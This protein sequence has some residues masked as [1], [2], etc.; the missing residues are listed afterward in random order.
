[1]AYIT[2]RRPNGRRIHEL[3]SQ[4]YVGRGT[5]CQ[6]LL[7]D[8]RSS[9]RHAEIKEKA[10]R[11]L[12]SDL[13]SSNGTRVRGQKVTNE[14]SLEDGD[15]IIIGDTTLVF[16]RG[17]PPGVDPSAAAG[18][19][20]GDKPRKKTTGAIARKTGLQISERAAKRIPKNTVVIPLERFGFYSDSERT[21]ETRVMRTSD[22][23]VDTEHW[24]RTLYRLLREANQCDSEDELFSAATRIL[25]ESLAGS[26]VQVLFEAGPDASDKD[27]LKSR[28]ETMQLVAWANPNR[29]GSR[30]TRIL[31]DRLAE[32]RS[33]LLT[34]ARER[35]VAVL[36]G[37]VEA[38]LRVWEG[39][40]GPKKK[41]TQFLKAMAEDTER[42]RISLLIAPLQ[43]G[44]ISLGYLVAERS[45]R[46]ASATRPRR[47]EPFNQAH[48]EFVAA[49]AYPLASML[50]RVRRRQQVLQENERLRLAV[51]SRHKIVGKSAALKAVLTVIQRVAPLTSPVLILGESGT[52]KELIARA[53]HSMS[54]RSKGP[55]EAVNCAALPDNLVESELF[56]HAKG[57]F[58]GATRDRAGY[59][60]T[61]SGGT[62]FLDEVGDLPLSAQAKLLRVVEESKVARVGETRL[63]DI[64]CRIV[65]ATNRDLAQEVE[66]GNF[67]QDLYY[68]LR[69]MD[70]TLPPL[71]D[72][73][74]DL[75]L[76]CKHLLKPFGNFTLHPEALGVLKS[77]HWPGNI[78][79]LKNTLERMAVMCRPTGHTRGGA[80][81]LT[82][83]D[84]PLDIRRALEDSTGAPSASLATRRKKTATIGQPE[85]EMLPGTF[86]VQPKDLVPLEELQVRYA[87]WV[88]EQVKGNKSKAARV[89]GIQRS[90]LYA[91]TD[92]RDKKKGKS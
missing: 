80:T 89:L 24:L 55:F 5:L 16:T 64:D 65:A 6:V 27:K 85:E 37:D 57:A 77:Y 18:G 20:S 10:G 9:K 40:G 68:R 45:H 39:G 79:E 29:R 31:E 12:L 32:A 17:L 3:G 71:R 42:E 50:E 2:V 78:R 41:T 88:L 69:V 82:V 36:S 56:G 8:I 33:I 74:E 21:A 38:D 60:E 35:C 58:T 14:V 11:F 49:A 62:L 91:W 63:R 61:A 83:E 47:G 51:E 43:T 22:E 26:R 44:R 75:V 1:M 25:A 76:L 67:R 19:G 52:G 54:A 90:T 92:W 66:A 59:F 48:L 84:I 7:D 30:T 86:R 87:K 46:I 70:V 81:Q 15:E 73:L 28:G 53:V 23:K 4:T 34:H 13:N 72:R